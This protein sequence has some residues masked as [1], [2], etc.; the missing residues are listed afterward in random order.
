MNKMFIRSYDLSFNGIVFT[1]ACAALFK[2]A[3]FDNSSFLAKCMHAPGVSYGLQHGA[4]I[5]NLSASLFLY[6]PHHAR[7]HLNL[8][9]A[10]MMALDMGM[11]VTGLKKPYYPQTFNYGIVVVGAL[12]N[13]IAAWRAEPAPSFFRGA[14][15]FHRRATRRPLEDSPF[16]NFSHSQ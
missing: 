13:F 12:I 11:T 14:Q 4:L 3:L 15:A 6:E 7:A 8:I 5:Y 16:T 2:E 9:W 10:S 1:F